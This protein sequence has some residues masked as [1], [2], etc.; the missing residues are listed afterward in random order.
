MGIKKKIKYNTSNG[1]PPF[2]RIPKRGSSIK[3]TTII[4]II[5]IIIITKRK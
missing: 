4:S 3:I 2:T 1:T 5:I